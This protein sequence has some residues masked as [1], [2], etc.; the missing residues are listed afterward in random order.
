[1]VTENFDGSG[2]TFQ[3]QLNELGGAFSLTEK[4]E[5]LIL[6]SPNGRTCTK[7]YAPSTT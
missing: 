3:F 4:T 2:E 1:M 5:K 6:Q 7:H